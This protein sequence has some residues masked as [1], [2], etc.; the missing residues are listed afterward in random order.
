M[1][2]DDGHRGHAREGNHGPGLTDQHG[3]ERQ[4]ARRQHRRDRRIAEEEKRHD[5]D[6]C[7]DGAHDRLDAE[8]SHRGAARH[9]PARCDTNIVARSAGTNPFAVSTSTTGSPSLRPNTRQTF[10]P[11]DVAAPERPD[12]DVPDTADEPVSSR[13]RAGDVA[14]DD[15]DGV[16]HGG[17]APYVWI[18]Y[19]DTQSSI[20]GQSRLSKNASMYDARSVW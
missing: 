2:D 18:W 17:A 8:E 5:P 7:P 10:V 14:R 9:H 20:V 11:P 3:D 13:N 19:F 4:R 1:Q 6:S 16:A 15:R 12:V